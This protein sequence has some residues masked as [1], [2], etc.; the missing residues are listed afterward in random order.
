MR[1]DAQL[2]RQV[3]ALHH[4]EAVADAVVPAV[5]P[6]RE[7]DPR[8]TDEAASDRQPAAEVR[9]EAAARGEAAARLSIDQN[10]SMP[11]VCAM[12]RTYSPVR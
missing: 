6:G 11:F 5:L 2:E 3:L 9:I 4:P 8:R 1:I 10:D 12:P 7:A